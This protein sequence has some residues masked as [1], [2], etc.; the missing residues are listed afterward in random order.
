[1]I[2]AR[3]VVF[4]L[5]EAA[6]VAPSLQI[7]KQLLQALDAAVI[8]LQ[9]LHKRWLWLDAR[10]STGRTGMIRGIVETGS[11]IGVVALV[12]D[13]GCDRSEKTRR[14]CD[15]SEKSESSGLSCCEKRILIKLIGYKTNLN[16]RE[17]LH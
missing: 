9:A 13:D 1:M 12:D 3:W 11:L 15:W 6:V 10:T 14:G 17:S 8:L 16:W 5:D 7:Y 2:R 4:A